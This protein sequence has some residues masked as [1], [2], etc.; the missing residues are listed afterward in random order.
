[1]K[2]KKSMLR[3]AILLYLAVPVF[4]WLF[5]WLKMI[6]AVPLAAALAVALA[7]ACRAKAAGGEVIVIGK[8]ALIA[9]AVMALFFTWISGIGGYYY[10]SADYN[11]RNAMLRDL[12]AYDWPV[13]YDYGACFV[14]Y[15]ALFLP[16]A[17]A[18]K[19]IAWRAAYLML[20]LWCAFGLTLL[21]VWL[22]GRFGIEKTKKA[23]LLFGAVM[24]FSGLDIV[25]VLLRSIL[26]PTEPTGLS[27]IEWWAYNVQYSSMLTQYMWVFNQALPVWLI[28]SLFEAE[29]GCRY[30][31]LLVILTALYSPYALF[32]LAP[33]M[34]VKLCV[35]I[36]EKSLRKV[37]NNIF[38]FGNILC[39]FAV[40]PAEY[41]FL[42]SNNSAVETGVSWFGGVLLQKP[43][44]VILFCAFIILEFLVY[45][46]PL[47]RERCREPLYWALL[48]E[49]MLLPFFRQGHSIDLSMR[50]AI[51]AMF[52]LMLYVF[53]AIAADRVCLSK[54]NKAGDACSLRAKKRLAA[55]LVCLC[56]GLATPVTEQIR[57]VSSMANAHTLCLKADVIYTFGVRNPDYAI[58][59]LMYYEGSPSLFWQYLARGR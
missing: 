2:I 15:F 7:A 34:L 19:L 45:W 27:H 33:L 11:W 59:V 32:G 13:R 29:D 48:A 12:I 23:A 3:A 24:L 52:I 21:A 47:F 46:L 36:K 53:D 30:Y 50:G 14:Y 1:M 8:G 18:G 28:T 35:F 38:C 54:K 9:V 42:S 26:L 6:F 20:Y 31:G 5:G 57:A 56:I 39:V 49:A 16:A 40:F 37:L 55:L 58:D 17:L 4:I 44:F 10:Q 22:C 51:P 25:G 43:A 41:L